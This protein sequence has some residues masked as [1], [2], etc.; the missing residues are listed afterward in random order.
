LNLI[1]AFYITSTNIARYIGLNDNQEWIWRR[2]YNDAIKF[3]TKSDAMKFISENIVLKEAYDEG[4]LW[5]L[6]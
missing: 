1:K 4:G 2:N 6:G 5:I 3:G